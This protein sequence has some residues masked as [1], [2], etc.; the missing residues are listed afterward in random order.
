MSTGFPVRPVTVSKHMPVDPD[1]VF[2]YVSDTRNDPEWCPNVSNVRQTSGDGVAVGS[3]FEFHQT[4]EAGG[5]TLESDVQVEIVELGNRSVR[6]RVEDRFQRRDVRLRVVPHE[7]GS[8]V[9]QTTEARFKR[10][11]GMAKWLYPFLAKR[12]F[13]DQFTRLAGHLSQLSN[14]DQT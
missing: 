6:W 4:V 9:T 5:K 11:P 7:N 8:K 2:R 1:T 13:R 14:R 12:T 10:K 3:T